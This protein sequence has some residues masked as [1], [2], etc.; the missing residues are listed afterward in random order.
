MSM[1]WQACLTDLDGTLLVSQ[2]VQT[3]AW[4]AWARARGVD[5]Q[6]LL[7]AHGTTHIEK[8]RRYAPHL[9]APIEAALVEAME[10][11]DTGGVR[12]LPG[13]AQLLG[14]GW[15]VAIVTSATRRLAHVR[16]A[17]AG[18]EPPGVMVCAEDVTHGKPH[19]E[20]YL[21]AAD[22]LGVLPRRCIAFEDAP[23]GVAAAV[24]A[25]A[26]VVAVTS[27]VNAVRLAD[28]HEVVP[29]LAAYLA[30]LSEPAMHE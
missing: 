1:R 19:P 10:I 12:A 11:A 2:G 5:V 8:I 18:L 17:A 27:T 4:S 28:A 29:D 22:L 7:A 24:A 25:G 15:L 26:Y 9:D 14:S 13:A 6:R 16:L 23:A 20:P 21:R 3:R 30:L